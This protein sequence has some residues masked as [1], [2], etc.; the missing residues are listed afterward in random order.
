MPRPWLV[1]AALFAGSVGAC[2]GTLPFVPAAYLARAVENA[3]GGR[4]VLAQPQGTIWSGS[5]RPALVS[6]GKTEAARYATLP[7]ALAWQ[8][9]GVGVAPPRLAFALSGEG[10]IGQPFR[11]L[12]GAG[13]ASVE[14][15]SIRLPAEL[16]EALGAPLNTLRPGGVVSISWDTLSWRSAAAGYAGTLTLEWVDARSALSP[17]A[18]LGSYRLRARGAGTQIGIDLTTIKGPLL[19]SGNGQWTSQRGVQFRGEARAE[20]A[21]RSEL[22]PL[23]GLLGR[24]SANGAELRFGS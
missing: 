16:L 22:S 17:V 19:L 10:V 12:F 1:L 5:V 15:G 23:V 21:R 2:A 13:A 6:G 20:S 9:E 14:P 3:S 18:P 4:V 24:P 11:I 8:V 7:A